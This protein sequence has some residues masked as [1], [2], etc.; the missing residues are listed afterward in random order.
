[1]ASQQSC[2][3][4]ILEQIAEAGVVSA[5]KMFGEYGIYCDEKIVALGSIHI[6]KSFK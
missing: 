2:V 1:M 5:K 3:D 4:F 6:W